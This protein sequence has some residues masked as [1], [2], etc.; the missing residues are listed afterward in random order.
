MTYVY[1]H[2]EP[3]SMEAAVMAVKT[4]VVSEKPHGN[5]NASIRERIKRKM[6]EAKEKAEETMREEVE[7]D[8]DK[9]F[10]A[11]KLRGMRVRGQL[12]RFDDSSLLTKEELEEDKVLQVR[13]KK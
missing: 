13:P 2:I 3:M 9:D 7:K 6:A 8:P 12:T 5:L 11:R 1:T 4:G 10:P